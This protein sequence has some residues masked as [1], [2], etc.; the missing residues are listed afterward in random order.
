MNDAFTK[1]ARTTELSPGKMIRVHV[2]GHAILLANVDGTYYATDDLCT[3]ED[4]SLSTGCL[5]GE[6]V[7][8]PLHGSRFD[9][10]TGQAMEDPAEDDLRTYPVKIAGEEILVGGAD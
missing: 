7:K 9:L 3:H 10:K 6:F 5:Q 1:V 4:A 8:C 2:N